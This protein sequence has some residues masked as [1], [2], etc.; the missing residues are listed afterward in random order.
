MIYYDKLLQIMK[1][2]HSHVFEFD[3]QLVKFIGA[4]ANPW[5]R[6]LDVARCLCFS[7][8]EEAV[9]E[10]VE[11]VNKCDL[12]HILKGKKIYQ[13]VEDDLGSIYINEYG[14]RSLVGSA[15]SEIGDRFEQWMKNSVKPSMKEIEFSLLKKLMDDLLIK[16]RN[17]FAETKFLQATN[18]ELHKKIH[19]QRWINSMNYS[20]AMDHSSAGDLDHL[21]SMARSKSSENDALEKK[22]KALEV[23]NDALRV[24][25]ADMKAYTS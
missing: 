11:D 10:Y 4:F 6:G 5:Y 14:M 24:L 8:P 21:H 25:Y 1:I 13:V 20:S 23:K 15:K 18:Y 7:D 9:R 22:I 2:I 3:G 16:S 12:E 19:E 17:L